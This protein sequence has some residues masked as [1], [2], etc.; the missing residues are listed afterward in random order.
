MSRKIL[1]LDIRSSSATA[2]LMESGFKTCAITSF[3]HTPFPKG[4]SFHDRLAEALSSISTTMD[5]RDCVCAL[6]LPTNRFFYRNISVPFSETKKIQQMLPYELESVIAVPVEDLLFDFNKI[7]LPG[8]DGETRIIAA[9][10]ET[11]KLKT[12]LDTIESCGIKPDIVLPAGYSQAAWI[13]SKLPH[14]G[15]QLYIDIDGENCSLYLMISGEIS[16]I[17]AFPLPQTQASPSIYLWGQIQQSIAGFESLFETKISTE[18]IILNCSHDERFAKQLETVSSITVERLQVKPPEHCNYP[19]GDPDAF[20][21][22]S[23]FNGALSNSL[24]LFEGFKGVNF[25]KGPLA[26]RN[27]IFEYKSRIIR[28]AVIAGILFLLWF[29]GALT[30]IFLTQ[31]KVDLLQSEI[32][33]IYKKHYPDSKNT[34]MPVRQMQDQV[35]AYK[36]LSMVGSETGT[37][38]LAIDLLRDISSLPENIN[39]DIT[40]FKLSDGEIYIAGT[41]ATYELVN[42]II[43]KIEA[44]ETVKAVNNTGSSR[45]GDSSISFKFRIEIIGKEASS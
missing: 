8:A 12:V 21:P 6:S 34:A 26:A 1:G 42:D 5:L 4:D 9:G 22:L 29:T 11:A 30:Q 25:R 45:E 38:I 39:V 14:S 43:S 18:L 28:T 41:T 19:E 44:L 24:F 32:M 17:R 7:P 37:Q 31:K 13:K 10:I 15:H 2:V 16:L 20:N 35:D 36:K 33:E 3:V 27:R 23:A 40:K